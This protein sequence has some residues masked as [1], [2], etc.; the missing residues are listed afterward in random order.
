MNR[1][2]AVNRIEF[3]VT[4]LCNSKCHHCQLGEEKNRIPSYIDKDKAVEIVRK[5]GEKCRPKSVMTFGGEPLL[6]PETVYAIHEQ[7]MNVGI[8][9]RGVITNGLWA[10]ET[11]RIEEIAT[12]LVRSGINDVH[13]SVDCFHQEFVPL[14]IVRKAAEALV[15][16]GAPRVVWNP[17]WVLS[18]NH[19][20]M[21]NRKTRAILQR[22]KD[23]PIEISEGNNVQP[24]GRA[25]AW[26]R[27]YLPSK[28]K[29]PKGKCGDMP[30][31]EPLDSIHTLCV[32]PDG[33]IAVCKELYVGNAFETDVVEII[34]NYDPFKIPEA[35]AIVEDGMGG[36]IDWARERNVEP[37]P[38]GY[39]NLCHLCTDLR[40]RAKLT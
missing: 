8:P 6:H 30:Y 18:K 9:G 39:Y 16:A 24:E 2:F 10:N 32:E 28:T 29:V 34:E 37:D 25:I 27:D 3:A 5:I 38:G 7:A 21:Y 31:T 13:I 11:E 35:K 15:K 33:R 4:Y 40:R 23:L 12:D 36:L 22:L 20:N 17:C 26:L 14:K 1:Y 19:D